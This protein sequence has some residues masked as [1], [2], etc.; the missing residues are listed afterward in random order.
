MKL[1]LRN[2]CEMF[3]GSDGGGHQN[4]IRWRQEGRPKFWYSCT[5]LLDV[6]V[7]KTVSWTYLIQHF[8]WMGT[9]WLHPLVWPVNVIHSFSTWITKRSF[10]VTI[11]YACAPVLWCSDLITL[12]VWLCTSYLQ[13]CLLTLRL[14]MSCMYGAPILDVSRSHTTT[15]HSR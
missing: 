1:G 10:A 15:H 8:L 12:S 2:W 5:E 3:G 6:T 4:C 9:W 7:Q 11:A 14:L 13:Q